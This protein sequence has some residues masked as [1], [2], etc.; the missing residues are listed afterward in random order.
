MTY[1]REKVQDSIRRL[2]EAFKEAERRNSWSWL[3]DEFYHE[4]CVYSCPYA[5][6]M[7]VV[8]NGREEIR[9][10]HYG[11]DMD[12][13]SGWK[14]W[15]F[16]IIDWAVNGDR[17][18]SHWLNR[19]LGKRPDGTHYETHGVAFITYGGDGKFSSQVDLFDVAHQMKLCDK[20]EDAGLLS[21]KLKEEWVIPMKRRLMTMLEH[22]LPA[23]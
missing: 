1:P 5:G 3:A 21:P 14:G 10:T 13:G 8:A 7:L 12:V 22:N 4:D 20:L 6:A 2:A 18:I 11:R 17:I 16:P 23:A 15:S 9:K 19:G